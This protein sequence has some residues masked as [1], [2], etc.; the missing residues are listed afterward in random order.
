[1]IKLKL[2]PI[3]VALITGAGM[4]IVARIA[5]FAAIA[6]PYREIIA[7][8]LSIAGGIIS[9]IGII[10]FRFTR[11]TVNPLKFDKVSSLVTSGIYSFTRNPMYLGLL[12]VLFGWL[13]LL[14]NLLAFIFIPSFVLYMNYF[15]I[16]PEES[17]L[18]SKFGEAFI[19]YKLKVRRW[20]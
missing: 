3:I 4:W 8:I 14:S 12:F 9:F 19:R 1:M 6:L 7:S 13:C 20:I 5:P 11:T 10:S 17:A 2:P 16:I 15:Q 18:E